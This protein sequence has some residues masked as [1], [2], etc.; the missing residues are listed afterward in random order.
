[1][2]NRLRGQHVLQRRHVLADPRHGVEAAGQPARLAAGLPEGHVLAGA[3]SGGGGLRGGLRGAPPGRRPAAADPAAAQARGARGGGAR[4]RH[5]ALP[6]R[7]GRPDHR[8]HVPNGVWC[9]RGQ[10]GHPEPP[11]G[12][13]EEGRELL[14]VVAGRICQLGVQGRETLRVQV[15]QGERAADADAPRHTVH[16]VRHLR[17]QGDGHKPRVQRALRVERAQRPAGALRDLQPHPRGG[18]RPGVPDA[19]LPA[20]ERAHANVPRGVHDRHHAGQ[21]APREGRRVLPHR[22]LVAV[23]HVLDRRRGRGHLRV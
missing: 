17:G 10:P 1:M 18:P 4:R 23:G 11:E 14:R 22:H 2:R 12:P 16:G 13:E 21:H 15:R 3:R 5:A 19:R 20:C 9:S 8:G 6:G 7:P